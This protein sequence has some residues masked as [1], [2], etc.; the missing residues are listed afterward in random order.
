MAEDLEHEGLKAYYLPWTIPMV[1]L[2]LYR[3]FRVNGYYAFFKP[4][5]ELAFVGKRDG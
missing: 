4:S 3:L 1:V 5:A 2:V